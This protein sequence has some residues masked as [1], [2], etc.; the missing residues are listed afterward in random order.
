[1]AAQL[2]VGECPSPVPSSRESAGIAE[3]VRAEL[4][5]LQTV[6]LDTVAQASCIGIEWPGTSDEER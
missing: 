6:R 1:M 4:S 3:F 2:A 5:I